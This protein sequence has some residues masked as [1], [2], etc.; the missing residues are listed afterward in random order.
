MNDDAP[1]LASDTD[2]ESEDGD[3]SDVEG[4]PFQTMYERNN[5][6]VDQALHEDLAKSKVVEFL[7]D[8]ALLRLAS[9]E[10]ALG[11][12]IDSVESSDAGEDEEQPNSSDDHP[13]EDCFAEEDEEP[14]QA[15]MVAM[16]GD[17][18]PVEQSHRI[19]DE[20]ALSGK[21]KYD[22]VRFFIGGFHFYLETLRMTNKLLR[23][24]CGSFVKQWRDTPGKVNW[25]LDP[26][27]PND[28]EL[29]L[30]PFAAALYRNAADNLSKIRGSQS[31]SP[32]EVDRHIVN[33]A[34]EHDLVMAVLMFQRLVTVTFMIRDSEKS[35]DKGDLDLF[36][37]G[38]RYALLLFCVTNARKY[39]RICM[40]FLTWWSCASDAEK[41]LFREFIYTKKSSRGKPIWADRCVEWMVKHLREFLG[42]QHL[43]GMENN[44][45]KR[46]LTSRKDQEQTEC[47]PQERRRWKRL[48]QKGGARMQSVCPN[49]PSLRKAEPLWRGTCHCAR[50]C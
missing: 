13:R 25:I 41:V 20:D 34:K 15:I 16:T 4:T 50:N 32:S 37:S 43:Q 2:S 29:E 26:G 49:V 7:M 46:P 39:V 31:L 44:V 19:R 27:D 9:N 5:I 40:E 33:R 10:K 48:E 6:T 17:G 23:D 3:D 47:R 38:V 24:I 28:L 21:N 30:I 42:K 22:K 8:K 11:H 35:G 18:S 14:V 1:G 36:I 45:K 12:D